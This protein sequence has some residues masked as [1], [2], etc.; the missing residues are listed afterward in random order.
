MVSR[1][2]PR[3]VVASPA[4]GQGKTTV[5]LG[6]MAAFARFG[7]GVSGHKVGP[8]HLDQ[9]YHWLATGRPGRNLDPWLVAE[10]RLVPLL[11][12]G[13]IGA[14]V[15]VIEGV[16]GLY[17]GQFG[18]AGFASTAH[19]ATATRT[20]V[21]LVVD[22]SHA[23]RSIGAVV[24]GMAGFDPSVEVGGVILNKVGSAR[25]VQEVTSSIDVPVLG[26]LPRDVGIVGPLRN[27]GA[28]SAQGQDEATQALERLADRTIDCVDI[29]QVMAL[30]DRAPDLESSTWEQLSVM[31]QSWER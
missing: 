24:R 27:R 4:S 18:G 5:A 16:M 14:N 17:D 11:L 12:H 13:A 30:A 25:H 10:G 20:P 23:T 2:L 1:C 29:G 9:D 28:V 26:A 8:P 7:F 31:H 15:A 19:V 22:V 3:F 6:L 21:L